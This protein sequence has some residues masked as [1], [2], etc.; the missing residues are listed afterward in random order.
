MQNRIN[1]LMSFAD[2]MSSTYTIIY[3]FHCQLPLGIDET[4][5]RIVV[6][7]VTENFNRNITTR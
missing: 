1:A 6:F 5:D 7:W 3:S 2:R 4:I